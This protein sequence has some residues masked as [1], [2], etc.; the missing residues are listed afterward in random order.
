MD[1]YP[2]LTYRDVEAALEFLER[3]FGFD[4]EDVGRDNQGAIRHA[5]LRHGQGLVLLQ[6]DVPDEL[7]GSHLGQGWVYVD[8]TNVDAH[9][10][11]ARAAGAEVLG[12]PHE[13]LGGTVRGYSA[14]DPEGN[15]WSFG[16]DLTE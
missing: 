10:E 12:E 9:F 16:T 13:A 2:S 8:V 3:A 1:V 15:L 6:P 14:R 11:R 4:P 5:A 7:H